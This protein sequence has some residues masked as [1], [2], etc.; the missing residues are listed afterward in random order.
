MNV[1][2][3]RNDDGDA[4]RKCGKA[5]PQISAEQMRVHDIRLHAQQ[6]MTRMEKC[7]RA[8]RPFARIRFARGRNAENILLKIPSSHERG[9]ARVKSSGRQTFKKLHNKPFGAAGAE[10]RDE[11]RHARP[12]IR[13]I[14]A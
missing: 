2:F 1:V 8:K 7:V 5:S 3:R 12:V 14:R 4:E 9:R 13:H 6:K 11:M 10:G